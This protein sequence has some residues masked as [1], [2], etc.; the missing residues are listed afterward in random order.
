MSTMSIRVRLTIAFATATSFV[1]V[2]AFLFVYVRLQDDLNDSIDNTLRARSAA[3]VELLDA[4]GSIG[5][6]PLEDNEEAFVQ[7]VAADGSV[8]EH[9]GDVRGV[10]LDLA[11]LQAVSED[12]SWSE[13]SVSGIDGPARLLSVAL[14]DSSGRVLV[15]GQALVNRDDS[16]RDV[17][18]SFIFGGPIAVLI[19]S[20]LGYTLARAGFA[21]VEAIR[22]SAAEM[23]LTGGGRRLPMPKARD[24]IHRLAIT[25]NEMIARLDAAFERERRFVA[26]ASHELRTPIAVVKTE[27]EAALLAAGNPDLLHDSLRAAIDE[28][29]ALAQLADD[30]LVIAREHEGGIPIHV[31][32]VPV[33]QIF[34]NVR[35]RFV[36]RA[37]RHDRAIE[38]EVA[39]ELHITADPIRLQQ[40]LSNL[41]DNAIRHGA[42]AITLRATPTSDTVHLDVLDD[43]DGF[44]SDIAGQAFER[45]TRSQRARTRTGA[46][47]GLAIVHTIAVAHDGSAHLLDSPGTG[48]RITLPLHGADVRS[49]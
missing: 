11:E 8:L 42:G 27:L 28:C 44:D 29:D 49:R 17:R 47:L 31:E 14:N 20:L 24:E 5:S 13:N 38:I 4:T 1:L 26:D 45:F 22:R 35:N 25:L 37:A 3:A 15:V 33:A 2:G 30:L 46:G 39:S 48:V 19:A 36:D 12:A 7:L 40:A 32:R 41:V 18:T 43:G 6:F 10:A 21:P 23:S 9:V 34:D 16:L